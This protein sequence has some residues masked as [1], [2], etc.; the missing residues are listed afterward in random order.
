MAGDPLLKNFPRAIIAGVETELP[1]EI[2]GGSL[3]PQHGRKSA[4]RPLLTSLQ[5]RA[6]GDFGATGRVH[7]RAHFH[8]SFVNRRFMRGYIGRSLP[9]WLKQRAMACTVS[10]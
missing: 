2:V 6:S 3:E 4:C 5:R 1:E 8:W 10:A 7:N 9:P